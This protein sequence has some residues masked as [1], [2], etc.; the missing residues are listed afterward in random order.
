MKRW[1]IGLTCLA[2]LIGV[3][4]T[5]TSQPP[6]PKK[7]G[8]PRF[9]LGDLFPPQ[10]K[11]ELRLSPEQEKAL[12]ELESEVRSKLERLLTAEQKAMLDRPPPKD[13]DHGRPVELIARD[14]GVTAEQF[15]EAFKKVQP[16]PIGQEP[17]PEQRQRNRKILSETL[18]VSPER[19]DEVMD[20]YRPGGKGTNGPPP[21]Q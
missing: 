21:K 11:N 18:K 6:P 10:V 9:Q 7:D 12:A 17:T 14:L 4:L 16:A 3:T 19:L 5:S 20:K 2:G 15:R 1:L 13:M 8:P